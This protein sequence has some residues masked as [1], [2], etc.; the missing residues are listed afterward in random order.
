MKSIIRRAECAVV[1]L[2]ALGCS[3]DASHPIAPS[4]DIP[5]LLN[6][7]AGADFAGVFA[8]SPLRPG[9]GGSLSGCTYSSTTG[10]FTCTPAT[11]N[12]LTITRS[13]VFFDA[14]G[15]AL[16]QPTRGSVASIRQT[17]DVSG[18]ASRNGTR[19]GGGAGAQATLT[20]TR[21]EVTTLTGVGSPRHVL[22]G[23][24]TSSSS[25]TATLNGVTRAVTRSAVDTI[26]NVVLVAGARGS[27]TPTWPASGGIVR[28]GTRTMESASA[29]QQGSVRQQLSFNGTSTVT[30]V[31][32]TP[33]GTRTCTRDLS[34]TAQPVCSS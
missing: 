25:G 33:R 30:M 14:N 10:N 32:T 34:S 26:S 22:N 6:E 27:T 31:V 28:V 3:G 16:A 8:G 2:L 24:G 7:L 19:G 15:Q 13:F 9:A 11:I 21:H 20:V 29:S 4:A 5:G 23:W 12:G 18:T 17:V 1:A